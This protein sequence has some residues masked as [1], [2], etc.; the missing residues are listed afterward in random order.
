MWTAATKMLTRGRGP[1]PWGDLTTPGRS[2]ASAPTPSIT[3]WPTA[4]SLV[5]EPSSI[6]GGG[7]GGGRWR[8]GSGLVGAAGG[9]GEGRGG[10]EWVGGTLAM[11]LWCA[12]V[13]LFVMVAFLWWRV[14]CSLECACGVRGVAVYMSTSSM[15]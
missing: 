12:A 4:T 11:L 14:E 13:V 10:K 2:R 7:G 3:R 6:A 15:L 5:R 9:S 1:W 8:V